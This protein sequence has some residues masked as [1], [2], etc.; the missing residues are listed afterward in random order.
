MYL[1][2]IRFEKVLCFFDSSYFILFR[3]FLSV[4]Q[5]LHFPL[6]NYFFNSYKGFLLSRYLILLIFNFNS[7]PKSTIVVPIIFII[8]LRITF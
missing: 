8:S 6:Y 5:I 1:F 3:F 7:I 2:I 4:R